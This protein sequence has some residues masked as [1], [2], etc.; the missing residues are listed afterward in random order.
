MSTPPPPRPPDRSL[1]I[2]GMRG[3]TATHGMNPLLLE[4]PLG[5]STVA[6]ST[7]LRQNHRFRNQPP[8]VCSELRYPLPPRRHRSIVLC[9]Q[10]TVCEDIIFIPSFLVLSSHE[11]LVEESRWFFLGGAIVESVPWSLGLDH[12]I[13][14]T[15]LF[16]SLRLFVLLV[17]PAVPQ[18]GV[19][20][21]TH[22]GVA[23][24]GRVEVVELEHR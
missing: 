15:H 16:R 17:E 10:E 13:T 6:P 8:A 5:C 19:A 9:K 7:F 22:A 12:C 4:V 23:V 3:S 1:G 14:T 2:V 20:P 21:P 24:H 11:T 18:A